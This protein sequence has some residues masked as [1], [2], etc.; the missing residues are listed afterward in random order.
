MYRDLRKMEGDKR[1]YGKPILTI[2]IPTR[3]GKIRFS[4]IKNINK[5]VSEKIKTQTII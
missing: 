3:T 1:F 4:F 5:R 2:L